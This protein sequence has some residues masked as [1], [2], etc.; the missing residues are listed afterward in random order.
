M[1]LYEYNSSKELQKAD[2]PF[3]GLI[4]AAMRGASTENLEKLQ[5]AF[6]NTYKEL[7]LRYNSPGGKLPED[8]PAF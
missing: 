1:S 7:E 4:M 3:Y 5:S 2:V 6:P 8:Y